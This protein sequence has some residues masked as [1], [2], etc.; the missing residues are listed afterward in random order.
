ML[1][2][3]RFASTFKAPD[4]TCNTR[5]VTTLY[6]LDVYFAI[7]KGQPPLLHAVETQVALPSRFSFWNTSA[8]IVF[9]QRQS[10]EP[11]DRKEHTV[12]DLLSSPTFHLNSGFLCEDVELGLCGT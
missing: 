5:L 9:Y 1:P 12:Y 4:L 11:R 3:L 8:L 6:K 10:E 7:L 2:S